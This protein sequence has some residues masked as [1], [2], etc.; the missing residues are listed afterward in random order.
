MIAIDGD[1]YDKEIQEKVFKP[2]FG[3]EP[4]LED[5]NLIKSLPIESSE[6]ESDN[7]RSYKSNHLPPVL[8]PNTGVSQR[9]Y[10]A[11]YPLPPET[12]ENWDRINNRHF[13]NDNLKFHI[14]EPSVNNDQSSKEQ[15]IE[16]KKDLLRENDSVEEITKSMKNEDSDI[17]SNADASHNTVLVKGEVHQ[18]KKGLEKDE[19][20][21]ENFDIVKDFFKS[22]EQSSIV[23]VPNTV[24]REEDAKLF[25]NSF[26]PILTDFDIDD[27]SKEEG[28]NCLLN[29][30]FQHFKLLNRN[31]SFSPVKFNKIN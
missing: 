14:R 7:T 21:T 13:N 19:S 16:G 31:F 12:A 1:G 3:H 25:K 17:L 18:V 20:A 9:E 23:E 22:Q 2:D 29:F 15:V 28:E 30:P 27:V 26:V 8:P 5:R 24:K 4:S 6:K 11:S 10:G